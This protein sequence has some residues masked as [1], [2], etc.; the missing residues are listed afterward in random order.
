[1]TQRK[2]PRNT[3]NASPIARARLAAGMTQKEL[4]DLLGVKPQQVGNWERGTRNPKLNALLQIADKCDCTLD[5]L[6]KK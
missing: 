1:M 5:D 4:A 6:I 3:G 2:A